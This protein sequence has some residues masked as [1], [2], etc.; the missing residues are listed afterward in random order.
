M[1]KIDMQQR[2]GEGEQN[3]AGIG[4]NLENIDEWVREIWERFDKDNSGTI[5]KQEVSKFV[6]NMLELAGM[7]KDFNQDDFDDLYERINL[8]DDGLVS[9]AEMKSF[10]YK[11]GIRAEAEAAAAT[12]K[13]TKPLVISDPRAARYTGMINELVNLGR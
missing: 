3:A 7:N 11:M 6:A 8:T 1:A 13:E 10:L 5:D 4:T 2:D 12:G 9:K